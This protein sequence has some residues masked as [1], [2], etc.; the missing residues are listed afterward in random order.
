MCKLC[1]LFANKT[2]YISMYSRILFQNCKKNNSVNF[3][4]GFW[5]KYSYTIFRNLR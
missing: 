4:Q 2:N 1:K 5:E 3:L